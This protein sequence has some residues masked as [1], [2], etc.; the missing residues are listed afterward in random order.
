MKI[1][2]WLLLFSAIAL[3]WTAMPAANAASQTQ[4]G[5]LKP[6]QVFD[7]KAGKVVKTVPNDAQF[8]QFASAWLK[9][10]TGLAPQATTEDKC[11]YVYRIPLAKPTDVTAGKLQLQ[12][13]DVFLFYCPGQPALLLIFDVERRPYLLTF[14]TDLQPFLKK[15]GIPAV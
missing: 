5:N 3:F 4:S 11:G 14:Q 12:V 7:V 6:V 9:G 15:I 1:Q 10:V 13:E 8:Q 2:R